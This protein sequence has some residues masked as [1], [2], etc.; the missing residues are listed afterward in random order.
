MNEYFHALDPTKELIEGGFAGYPRRDV[1]MYV[2]GTRH[3][4]TRKTQVNQRRGRM[5]P[6]IEAFDAIEVQVHQVIDLNAALRAQCAS[7]QEQLRQAQALHEARQ[8]D[9]ASEQLQQA[10]VG[11]DQAIEQ[12]QQAIGARDQAI[13]QLQQAIAARDQAIEQ[14]AHAL[15]AAELAINERDQQIKEFRDRMKQAQQRVRKALEVLP[16]HTP[17]LFEEAPPPAR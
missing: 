15:S 4:L 2:V 17:D 10:I 6:M 14:Q 13:G 5:N 16:P 12:L 9:Q 11:R 1:G 7:L 3:L 8:G